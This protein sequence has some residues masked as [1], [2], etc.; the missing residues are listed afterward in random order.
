MAINVLVIDDSAVMRKIVIRDLKLGGIPLGV[1][2]EAEDGLQGLELIGKNTVDLILADIN[3]PKMSGLEFFNR[4]RL[5][6][7]TAKIPFVFVSSESASSTLDFLISQ[8]ALLVH[9][10]FTPDV[11]IKTIQTALQN[12][13]AM[14]K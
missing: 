12:T 14:K 1:I 11:L 7:S 6:P 3:M 8:G 4:T 2:L 10:P 9:K 13:D 5:L